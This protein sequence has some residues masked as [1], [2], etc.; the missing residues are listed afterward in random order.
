MSSTRSYRCRLQHLVRTNRP[1]IR[2]LL[3]PTRVSPAYSLGTDS[4]LTFTEFMNPFLHPST[5]G[6]NNRLSP[7]ESLM[8]TVI[9]NGIGRLERGA[10]FG[11]AKYDERE[12]GAREG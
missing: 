9:L 10:G 1:P 7:G 6:P 4:R 2:D 12:G 11:A 8:C 5:L 3:R